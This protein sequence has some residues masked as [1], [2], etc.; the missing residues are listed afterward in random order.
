MA[1]SKQSGHDL[2]SAVNTSQHYTHSVCSAQHFVKYMDA[3]CPPPMHMLIMAS[4]LSV[5]ASSYMTLI[6]R[7]TPVAPSG[8]PMEIPPP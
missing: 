3:P 5:R 1:G 7:I 2:L 6:V 4:F 8:W